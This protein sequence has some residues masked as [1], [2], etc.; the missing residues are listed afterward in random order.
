MKKKMYLKKKAEEMLFL[1]MLILCIFVGSIDITQLN[2]ITNII[3]ASS[4]V[5][6]LLGNI[7]VLH[8]YGRD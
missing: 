5:G 8:K 3:I 6:V 7:Y 1:S 4:F 2:S